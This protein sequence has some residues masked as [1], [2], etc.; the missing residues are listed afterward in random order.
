MELANAHDQIQ[1]IKRDINQ[2]IIDKMNLYSMVELGC[3]KFHI[4][5]NSK[6]LP[7]FKELIQVYRR[8]DNVKYHTVETSKHGRI[9]IATLEVVFCSTYSDF[10]PVLYQAKFDSPVKTLDLV[11]IKKYES[12]KDLYDDK[13]F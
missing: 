11:S 1:K 10:V 12:H 2:Q 4:K 8:H 13:I 3:F 5:I 7:L 9:R 6:S